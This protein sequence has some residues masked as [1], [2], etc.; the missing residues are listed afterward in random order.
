MTFPRFSLWSVLVFL[1]AS[2]LLVAAATRGGSLVAFFLYFLVMVMSIGFVNFAAI[3]A[4]KRFILLSAVTTP[5]LLL[6]ATVFMPPGFAGVPHTGLVT[7]VFFGLFIA[8]A[9]LE[10]SFSVNLL[11]VLVFWLT[12]SILHVFYPGTAPGRWER[13]VNGLV[14][15]SLFFVIHLLIQLGFAFWINKAKVEVARQQGTRAM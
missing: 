6:M 13:I 5:P 15:F 7:F 1:T 14:Q 9:A 4:V 3:H 8:V 12:I 11:V 2:G 10:K